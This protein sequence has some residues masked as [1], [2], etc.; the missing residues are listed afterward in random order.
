MNIIKIV[1]GSVVLQCESD[2]DYRDMVENVDFSLINR[3]SLKVR[4]RAMKNLQRGVFSMSLSQAERLS[5]IP[6][7]N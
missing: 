3:L 4:E 7:Q 5:F 2:K 6:R 1:A